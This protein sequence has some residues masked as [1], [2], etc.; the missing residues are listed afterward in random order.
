MHFS[1]LLSGLVF[2]ITLRS[3]NH[4]K[5]GQMVCFSEHALEFRLPLWYNRHIPFTEERSEERNLS[6]WPDRV[7]HPN[8]Y[9][10]NPAAPENWSF[11]DSTFCREIRRVNRNRILLSL[12]IFGLIFY[13]DTMNTIYRA[14]LAYSAPQ[15]VTCQELAAVT[16]PADELTLFGFSANHEKSAE[17]D[18]L[19]ALKRR[20]YAKNGSCHLSLTPLAFRDLLVQPG[21][22][23]TGKKDSTVEYV[24]AQIGDEKYITVKRSALVKLDTLTGT[25][26]YLPDDLRGEILDCSDIRSDQLCSLIFD[27]TGEA[28][29]S[30]GTYIAFSAL[31]IVLWGVWFFFVIR[32]SLSIQRDP[33]YKRLFAC[34]GSVEENAR[35]IDEELAGIDCYTAGRTTVTEH[36]RLRRRLFSFLAE[37]RSSEE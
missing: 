30:T 19:P 2:A 11:H 15:T 3:K 27:A 37:P 33:A 10:P 4:Q 23:E 28:F 12:V 13:F 5:A 26:G 36:W 18:K 25:V 35:Q 6:A 1:R 14:R 20:M 29:S 21:E 32:R 24:L 9:T 34:L 17:F 16:N 7:R 8:M 22:R 31:L